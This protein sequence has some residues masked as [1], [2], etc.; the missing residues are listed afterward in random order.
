MADTDPFAGLPDYKDP[1]EDS[2]KLPGTTI[3]GSKED[4]FSTLR[5]YNNVPRNHFT[6]EEE[7][8][9]KDWYKSLLT[10]VGTKGVVANTLGFPGDIERA[11]KGGA[12]WLMDKAGAGPD[13]QQNVIGT[14]NAF[15]SS[16]DILNSIQE[17]VPS[18]VHKPTTRGGEALDNIGQFIAPSMAGS[19]NKVRQ[20]VGALMAGTG[21]EV[22]SEYAPKGSGW[23]AAARVGGAAL[24][25]HGASKAADVFANMGDAGRAATIGI[26][27]ALPAALHGDLYHAIERGTY[28]GLAGGFLNTA[29]NNPA[30]QH[31]A[32][33][34]FP[35]S[36]AD[37]EAMTR[38]LMAASP[39]I[40]AHTKTAQSP[41]AGRVEDE[42]Q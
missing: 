8:Y 37:R 22:A 25:G 18:M 42:R 15:P 5:D 35:N 12:H 40:A 23:E 41:Y 1:N 17:H 38:A 16:Q 34:V 11:S 2:P 4:P 6:G 3:A 32:R 7:P 31:A 26:G 29:V 13:T 19:G 14:Q 10:G 30:L 27:S 28:G 39:S 36:P 20:L 21:S 24:G 9:Y 33:Q